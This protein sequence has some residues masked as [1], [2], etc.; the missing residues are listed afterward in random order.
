MYTR[1]QVDKDELQRA[2]DEAEAALE[3]E[4]SKV[5][6]I[7]RPCL[8]TYSKLSEFYTLH[9]N[10]SVVFFLIKNSKDETVQYKGS[11]LFQASR[12]QIEI[13]QIRSEIEKRISEKEEEFEN[14]RK[15]HQHH[16]ESIQVRGWAEKI[17][18]DRRK[19]EKREEERE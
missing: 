13:A 3:A 14:A 5:K 8:A 2:L 7:L 4:E 16:I 11:S 6:W 19:N 10:S 12:A 17:N 1:I 9:S 18:R 15:A